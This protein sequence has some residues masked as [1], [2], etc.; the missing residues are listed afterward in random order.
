MASVRESGIEL[1]SNYGRLRQLQWLVGDWETKSEGAMV[2]TRIRWIAERSFL[3]RQYTVRTGRRDDF[4][5]HCRSSAGTRRPARCA[6]GRST[7][8]GG[9][10][11]G[12]LDAD[13]RKAGGSSPPGVLA[14]GTPT[15]SQDFLI[16]VPDEDNVLGWRSVNRKAGDAQLPDTREVVLE[17]LPEKQPS[18]SRNDGMSPRFHIFGNE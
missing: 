18:T 11:T 9:H 13:A 14:D 2:Q 4:F 8:S 10:G 5:R 1:P 17:R 12:A 6:R 3:Q 16:R 15:S 7:P